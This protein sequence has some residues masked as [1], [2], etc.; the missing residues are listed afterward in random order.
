MDS[1]QDF[2]QNVVVPPQPPETPPGP[3]TIELR[4]VVGILVLMLV[5]I[6]GL[7]IGFLAY[8]RKVNPFAP[9]QHIPFTPSVAE[10]QAAQQEEAVPA[11]SA[12]LT[13]FSSII[14]PCLYVFYSSCAK[15]VVIGDPADQP[16]VD[17]EY[18]NTVEQDL[19]AAIS[20]QPGKDLNATMVQVPPD[21]VEVLFPDY[22]N[23]AKVRQ[24][25]V[26]VVFALHRAGTR[27]NISPR[28]FL[29]LMEVLKNG[30]GILFSPAGD[31]SQPFFTENPGF[32]SQLITAGEELRAIQAKYDLLL[33]EQKKF[34]TELT[35]FGKKYA[36]AKGTNLESVVIIEF[37][38]THAK[39]KESFERMVFPLEKGEDTSAVKTQ[40]FMSA[41]QF[42]FGEDPR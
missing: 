20:N 22:V 23:D 3:P 7:Y 30:K 37:L 21:K 15:V 35:F 8:Q 13:A 6:A 9:V 19:F 12:S 40:N 31:V 39:N 42:A 34:P 38:G 41:Y 14:R 24:V 17:K 28:V 36:V 29:V 18:A 1:T 27:Y 33:K 2:N 26:P 16:P 5:I 4:T 25:S 11:L 10:Q 32:I